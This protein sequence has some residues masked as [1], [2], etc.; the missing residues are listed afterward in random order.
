MDTI[1]ELSKRIR[2][3]DGDVERMC[4][5]QY[6]DTARLRQVAGVGA[7]T[8]LA[9][10]LVIEHP[11][12]FRNSRA[13]GPYLGLCP[14]RSQSGD[15]DPQLR[16]TQAGD[17]LLRK[18]LVNAAHYILG[19]FGPDTELRRWGN[20]LASRGGK[21]AKKRATV[22]IARKLSGLL[23]S[24]WR[25]AEDY[26]PNRRTR[27]PDVRTGEATTQ[28]SGSSRTRGLSHRS[29]SGEPRNSPERPPRPAPSCAAP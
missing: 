12:R 3:F 28:E 26:E 16:I 10:V 29:Q 7:L 14:K 19:P 8:A 6:P 1:E 5:Q 18:L 2:A 11:S 21:N 22:A 17:L 25:S 27:E 23:Y 13:V 9:Y 15:N 20:A 24:L 4:E